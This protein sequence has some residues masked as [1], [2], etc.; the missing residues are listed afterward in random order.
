MEDS[1]I[2]VRNITYD[3][4]VF[5]SCKQQKNESVENFYGRLIEQDEKCSL[6]SEEI[7]YSSCFHTKHRS[8]RS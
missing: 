8:H 6:G 3:R 7:T 1:F 2:K 4:F 5:Y